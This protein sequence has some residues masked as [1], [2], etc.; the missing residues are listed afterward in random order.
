MFSYNF[1][2]GDALLRYDL[3][4]FFAADLLPIEPCRFN[5]FSGPL[6]KILNLFFRL[7]KGKP[8]LFPGQLHE[9]AINTLKNIIHIAAG[10]LNIVLQRFLISIGVDVGL[11]Q[12]N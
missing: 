2:G 1:F 10:E 4:I 5:S 11:F 3:R 9:V 6:M 8:N 12:K 7:F